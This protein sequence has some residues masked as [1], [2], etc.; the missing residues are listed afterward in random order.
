VGTG[1]YTIEPAVI[2]SQRANESMNVTG[3]MEA[4]IR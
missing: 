4:E 1:T 3:S 2:Q